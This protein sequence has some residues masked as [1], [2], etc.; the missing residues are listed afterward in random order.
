MHLYSITSCATD[1]PSGGSY[2]TQ[3][4][5]DEGKFLLWTTANSPQVCETRGSLRVTTIRA[6]WQPEIYPPTKP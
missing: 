1:K 3:D 6:G 2:N 5:D 4:A